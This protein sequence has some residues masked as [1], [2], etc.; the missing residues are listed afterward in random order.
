MFS[1]EYIIAQSV[2]SLEFK[3]N[4]LLTDCT[5]CGIMA[6]TEYISNSDELTGAKPMTFENKEYPKVRVTKQAHAR[7]T[8]LIPAIREERGV[9]VSMTDLV[10][11]LIM[12]QPIPQP[13]VVE[14]KRTR[15]AVAVATSA[16]AV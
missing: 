1:L 8:L 7:L 9:N 5:R 13:Q 3:R 4:S 6:S 10:S 16:A 12:S 15:K 11:E 2:N 14:K